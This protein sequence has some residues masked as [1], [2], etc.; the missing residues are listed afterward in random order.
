MKATII[1]TMEIKIDVPNEY[2]PPECDTDEKR[3]AY[4]LDAYESGGADIME[5]I[6]RES[7]MK[8]KGKV[9]K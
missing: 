9:S 1:V 7:K 8:I 2:Y 4:E 3:L 6:S 5:L